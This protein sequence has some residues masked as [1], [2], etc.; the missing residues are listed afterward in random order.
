MKLRACLAY[1]VF[2]KRAVKVLLILAAMLVVFVLCLAEYLAPMP[3]SAF[4]G[5]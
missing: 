1:W 5:G 4:F 3:K 2:L